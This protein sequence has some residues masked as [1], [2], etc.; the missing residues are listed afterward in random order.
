MHMNSNIISLYN[1][2][3]RITGLLAITNIVWCL[4]IMVQAFFQHEDLNEYVTQDKENPANWKVPIITLF[5]LSVSALLVYYT[6]LWIS[7]GLGLST[8]IIPIACYCTEF[9]FINDYRKVL[10]LHVYR[11]WHWGIVCLGEGL[12]LLTIFSSIIFLIFTNIVTNY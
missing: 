3:N 5:V 8:V 2:T 10:T 1:L 12:V 7:G 6:P 9:Y 11:S 4:L